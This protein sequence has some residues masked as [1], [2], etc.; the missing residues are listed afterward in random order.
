MSDI[1]SLSEIQ[2]TFS[3]LDDW[4]QRYAYL[5]DLGRKLPHFPESEKN[6]INTNEEMMLQKQDSLEE[7]SAKNKTMDS[8]QQVESHGHAH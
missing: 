4:E 8:L 2:E 1:P 5:I 3:I 6:E 7:V